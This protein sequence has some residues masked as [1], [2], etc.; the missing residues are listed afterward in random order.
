MTTK[1]YTVARR[2]RDATGTWGVG[3]VVG[4]YQALSCRGACEQASKADGRGLNALGYAVVGEPTDKTSE[5]V[6]VV[7]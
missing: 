6:D 4:T 5:T 3:S 1:T 2:E 7:R